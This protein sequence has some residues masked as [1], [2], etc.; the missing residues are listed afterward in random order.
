MEMAQRLRWKSIKYTNNGKCRQIDISNLIYTHT[1]EKKQIKPKQNYIGAGWQCCSQ[2]KCQKKTY[3]LLKKDKKVRVHNL[4]KTWKL[5]VQECSHPETV[6]KEMTSGHVMDCRD[7]G[8]DRFNKAWW[9][10]Q[11]VQFSEVWKAT[12]KT[13]NKNNTNLSFMF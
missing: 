6:D 3:I 11:Q 5:K 2:W 9:Q 13:Y 7:L 10:L 8:W 1:L 4:T 12:R